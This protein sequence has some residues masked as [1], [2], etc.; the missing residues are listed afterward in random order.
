[1]DTILWLF[2]SAPNREMSLFFEIFR[3]RF[4]RKQRFSLTYKKEPL[5]KGRCGFKTFKVILLKVI[6][7][8]YYLGN[9][10]LMENKRKK[11]TARWR[12][13]SADICQLLKEGSSQQ[14]DFEGQIPAIILII[15][16]DLYLLIDTIGQRTF[17][18]IVYLVLLT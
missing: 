2:C 12:Y 6:F 5:L 7:R 13:L 11:M 8:L 17:Q 15:P 14:I 16:L 18:Q 4:I 9:I 1:M 10:N 3:K